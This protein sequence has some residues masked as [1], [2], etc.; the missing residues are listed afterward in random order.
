M[1]EY[2]GA[3]DASQRG[4]R[5]TLF[6]CL[7]PGMDRRAGGIL[8][9]NASI[10]DAVRKS[11]SWPQ[12]TEVDPGRFDLLYAAGS[13]QQ[14]RLQRRSW[15]RDEAQALDSPGHQPSRGFHRNAA[16]V[17][18]DNQETSILDRR[19]SVLQ[20]SHFPLSRN[21]IHRQSY[22]PKPLPS[23]PA[24]SIQA[25]AILGVLKANPNRPLRS[26]RISPPLPRTRSSC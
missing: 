16:V 26:T 15:Q 19:E 17:R 10:A 21:G 8:D 25:R 9:A 20:L 6:S 24:L 3:D 14:I 1:G 12:F 7:Q 13:N 22:L 11:G 5:S 23:L 2:I 18:G 4:E